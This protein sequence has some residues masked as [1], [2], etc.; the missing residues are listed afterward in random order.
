MLGFL[1][2]IAATTSGLLVQPSVTP[3][4]AAVRMDIG[5]EPEIID[6]RGALLSAAVLLSGMPLAAQAAP[7]TYI[8]GTEK[9]RL[10]NTMDGYKNRPLPKETVEMARKNLWTGKAT[11]SYQLTGKTGGK[12]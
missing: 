10:A 3:R 12:K 6:R 9:A 11:S 5:H 7:D 4:H 2:C 1:S 8:Q